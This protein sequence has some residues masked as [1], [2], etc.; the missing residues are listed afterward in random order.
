MTQQSKTNENDSLKAPNLGRDAARWRRS[1]RHGQEL[2]EDRD[3]SIPSQRP[4]HGRGRETES[5]RRQ[6]Q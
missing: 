3:H 2:G 6:H 5:P 4:E 1:R